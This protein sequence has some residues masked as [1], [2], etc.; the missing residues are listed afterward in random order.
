[1]GNYDSLKDDRL[2][3]YPYQHKP[4]KVFFKKIPEN[5]SVGVKRGLFL[6]KFTGRSLRPRI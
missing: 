2:E 1:M 3:I 5:I 4:T 6:M